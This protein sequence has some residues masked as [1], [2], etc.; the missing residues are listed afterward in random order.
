MSIEASGSAAS[1]KHPWVKPT[2]V[3]REGPEKVA[4]P[5][6]EVKITGQDPA[7]PHMD[8]QLKSLGIGQNLNVVT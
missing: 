4:R 6:E 3:V 1:A 5:V 2:Q 7:R 8:D